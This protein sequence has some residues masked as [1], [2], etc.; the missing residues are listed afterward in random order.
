MAR[1]T[2]C[3]CRPD[4]HV[5]LLDF[6]SAVERLREAQSSDDRA[7]IERWCRVALDR[8]QGV[9]LP[10]EG[11]AE[12]VVPRRESTCL[13]AVEAASTLARLLFARGECGTCASVCREGLRVD[14]YHDGL[15]RMLIDAGDAAGDRAATTVARAGY[16]RVLAELEVDALT[17]SGLSDSGHRKT[18]P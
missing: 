2:A 18:G 8:F 12:W 6:E 7:D 1:R 10:E 17:A 4:T 15:W 14:R 3:G 11:P 5:D 16:R 9:L 13:S